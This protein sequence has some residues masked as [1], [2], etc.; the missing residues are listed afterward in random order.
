MPLVFICTASD[1]KAQADD[2]DYS[3]SELVKKS[4]LLDTQS[5][6]QLTSEPELADFIIFVESNE[7]NFMQ[8]I[9]SH[10][11][12]HRHYKKC[13][14]FMPCDYPV[15]LIPGI[16]ASISK[17]DYDAR[18]TRSGFYIHAL[19]NPFLEAIPSLEKIDK[20]YL[21]SFQGSVKN[22]PLREQ[23][24]HIK[25]PD[26]YFEDSS[27]RIEGTFRSA[28]T[29]ARI[30]MF[31][32]YAGILSKSLFILAPRGRGHSSV[33]L[34]ESLQAGR[35]PVIISDEWVPPLGPNWPSFSIQIPENEIQIIPQI[36]ESFRPKAYAMGRKARKTWE[37]YFSP[38]VRFHTL[39]SQCDALRHTRSPFEALIKKWVWIKTLSRI[40]SLKL[41]IRE[42]L[43][44]RHFS[45]HSSLNSA[46][47]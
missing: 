33:R 19:E 15:P 16:Y 21:F 39:A 9:R 27:G 34:F 35:V 29:Q 45:K 41:L 20:P 4:A 1:L 40:P 22:H 46:R 23:I 7:P 32:N 31:K 28:D 5:E 37:E 26:F 25:H 36:L 30:Q 2:F 12:Y 24:R 14:V 47:I 13:F 38:K 3:A 6:Y 44:Q 17:S 10:P 42:T 43:Q 11:L 8:N 18:R